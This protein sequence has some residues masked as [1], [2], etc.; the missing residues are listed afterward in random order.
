M[1]IQNIN[2]LETFLY[3]KFS[4]LDGDD[5]QCKSAKYPYEFESVMNYDSMIEHLAQI[6]KEYIEDEGFE[7]GASMPEISA[8][9]W[10]DWLAEYDMPDRHSPC[11]GGSGCNYCLMTSY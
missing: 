8:D 3:Q 2:D 1:K 11:C 9:Q 10:N 6:V 4:N 7:W 5:F